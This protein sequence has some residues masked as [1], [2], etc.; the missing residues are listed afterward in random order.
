MNDYTAAKMDYFMQL[1]I[2]AVS[3]QCTA[4]DSPTFTTTATL[5]NT[6]TRDQVPGLSMSVDPPRFF[7]R[8]DVATYLVFYGPAGSTFTGATVDGKRVHGTVADHLGRGA[9][10]V[11]VRNVPTQ[12]HTVTATFTGAEGPYGAFDLRHTPMVRP[13]GV[14]LTAEGCE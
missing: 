2:T 7:Q 10:K 14:Q 13:V 8:G 1:D 11:A 4:P 6:I 5:T 9:V 3:T 12:T